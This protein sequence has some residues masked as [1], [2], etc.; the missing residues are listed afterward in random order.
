MVGHCNALFD[1][2]ADRVIAD[3][4]LTGDFRASGIGAIGC[5]AR[6]GAG[7]ESRPCRLHVFCFGLPS[8]Q[9][10][11]NRAVGGLLHLSLKR[12]WALAC[13]RS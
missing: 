11:S 4:G 12:L 13:P 7:A 9:T 6:V 3:L 2:D 5:F 8:G 10:M 1:P